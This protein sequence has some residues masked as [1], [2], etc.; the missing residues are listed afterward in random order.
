[1]GK[2]KGKESKIRITRISKK[3]H[4]VDKPDRHRNRLTEPRRWGQSEERRTPGAGAS[5]PPGWGGDGGKPSGPGGRA[6]RGVAG[7]REGRGASPPAGLSRAESPVAGSHPAAG[8]RGMGALCEP[9]AE[10]EQPAALPPSPPPPTLSKCPQGVPRARATPDPQPGGI[11]PRGRARGFRALEGGPGADSPAGAAVAAEVPEV[12][13]GAPKLK[14]MSREQRLGCPGL[15]SALSALR[16]SGRP[17]N[18][19][20]HH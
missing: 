8:P 14:A 12:P 5:I 17:G 11:G 1:M 18:V 7:S 20:P 2:R 13:E 15:R 4:S 6:R 10:P 19:G 16:S 3:L 9:Q